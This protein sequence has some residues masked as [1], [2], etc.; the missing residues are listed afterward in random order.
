MTDEYYM[1]RC[2]DLAQNGCGRVAPNPLVGA[3]LVHEGEI[4]GEGF[5]AQYGQSHAEVIAINSVLKNFDS[6]PENTTLYVNLEPCNHQG[7][8][9]PCTYLIINSGIKKVVIG[10]S[11]PNDRVGG[12]GIENLRQAGIEVS[13]GI[14][15]NECKDLNKYFYNYFEHKRPFIILKWAQSLDG[16]ISSFISNK[17]LK[18][19][20]I[21]NEYSRKLTHKWRSE[22]QAILVGTNT[23]LLDNP[24]LTTRYWKGNNAFRI[25]LDRD[26]KLPKYLHFYDQSTK[27][28]C[29]TE[30]EST[31]SE[32]LEFIKIKFDEKLLRNIL[33]ELYHRNIQS[34]IVEGGA[35]LMSSFLS[36]NIW[37][38]GRIFIGNKSFHDGLKASGLNCNYMQ[39]L[40]I[41]GDVLLIFKDTISQ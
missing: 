35:E 15:E 11:D 33:F 18:K 13:K 6:I 39:K 34:L 36:E 30:K 3:V 19:E 37:D 41:E 2:I 26:M 32:N 12:M 14:L 23:V 5:H 25:T 31:K 38:E 29:F 16:F 7:K 28:L 21:S 24:V 20:W 27:T 8:T 40:N 17:S 22:T 9:P 1:R 4:I 10:A